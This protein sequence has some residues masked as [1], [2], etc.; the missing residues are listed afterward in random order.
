MTLNQHK[1]KATY[2]L[3]LNTL[4]FLI[5]DDKILLAM[6]KRGFG[7]GKWNGVGGKLEKDE[8]VEQALLR[9][10]KEE[11]IVTPTKFYQVATID[12]Y[13][14][15]QFDWDRRVIVYFA[16][17]WEGVPSNTEEM[18]PEWYDREKIPY[19][20]MWEDD[21]YWLPKV[22]EGEIIHGEFLFDENQ[23]LSHH[24]IMVV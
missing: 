11:I 16:T 20:L 9:E 18:Q 12:F 23:K 7:A 19:D 22:L 10:T 8:T 21:K 6:K 13:F 3:K 2:P 24:N 15:S 1:A 17:E 14:D 4:C 5:K